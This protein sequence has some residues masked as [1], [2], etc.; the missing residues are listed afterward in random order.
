MSDARPNSPELSDTLREE[1]LLSLRR[2]TVDGSVPLTHEF[3]RSGDAHARG[4]Y[5]RVQAESPVAQRLLE[6]RYLAPIPVMDALRAMDEGTLGRAFAS[7]IDDNGLDVNKLRESAFIEAHARDG[8]DQGYL[9]ERGFQLHD[10]FHVLTGYDTSPLGEVGV[11]S[12]TAAQTLSPYPT[13]IMTTRPLQMALYEPEL[14]PFVMDTVAEGWIRGRQADMLVGVRWEDH[15]AEP[16][17]DL[18]ERHNLVAS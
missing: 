3:L 4:T 13:F 5:C 7:H 10:L 1:L 2:W 17:A 14:L 9:A 15:W 8:E 12:F 18:R 16:L 6:E 11:V